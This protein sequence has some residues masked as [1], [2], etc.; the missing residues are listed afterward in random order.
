M[1]VRVN[2]KMFEVGGAVGLQPVQVVPV[3]DHHPKGGLNAS[4]TGICHPVHPP[5]SGAIPDMEVGDRVES[6]VTTLL[7]EQVACSQPLEQG[8]QF[9]LLFLVRKP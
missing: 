9:F 7:Q 6:C 5:D 8:L 2:S 3:V 1:G 4:W